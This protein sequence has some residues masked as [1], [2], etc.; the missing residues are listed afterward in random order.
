MARRIILA[1]LMALMTMSAGAQSAKSLISEFRHAKGAEY[2]HVP[3]L[4]FSIAG[5]M[6]K[7]E[8]AE[9]AALTKSL[10]SI[11]TLQIDN[12]KD[13]TRRKIMERASK[14]SKS[15][16]LEIIRSNEDG[17]SNIIMTLSRKDELRELVI[18]SCEKKEC[19][20]VL[21]TGRLKPSTILKLVEQN[22][23]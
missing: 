7:K 20:I 21:I 1:A 13:K 3:R 15:G 22:R 14:L 2:V 10:H 16:Y 19:S 17:E 12:C 11:R 8:D 6:A 4:L 23:K 9:Q 5:R 18:V